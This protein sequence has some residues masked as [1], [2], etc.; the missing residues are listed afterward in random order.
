MPSDR[1][2][3]DGRRSAAF[4]HGPRECVPNFAASRMHGVVFGT[5]SDRLK[6]ETSRIPRLVV[7]RSGHQGPAPGPPHSKRCS[8][9]SRRSATSTCSSSKSAARRGPGPARALGERRRSALSSAPGADRLGEHVG[10]V[11]GVHE[12]A[13]LGP[14]PAVLADALHQASPADAHERAIRPPSSAWSMPSTAASASI[15]VSARRLLL[16]AAPSSSDGSRN[17]AITSLPTSWSSA[18]V[19]VSARRA[20]RGPGREELGAPARP[21]PSG[22]RARPRSGRTAGGRRRGGG[23]RSC[24]A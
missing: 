13:A 5:E 10:E 23:A 9:S 22:A 19:A 3:G 8:T 2:Q 16:R 15:R 4:A 24:P 11:D 21:P 6:R 14:G 20:V 18:A 1:H 12:R 17:R 7:E